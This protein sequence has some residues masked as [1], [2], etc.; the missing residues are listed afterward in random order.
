MS[1]SNKF[2]VSAKALKRFLI[3]CTEKEPLKES[4]TIRINEDKL[5]INGYNIALMVFSKTDFSFSLNVYQVGAL[6]KL[7][8]TLE[9]QPLTILNEG[10]NCVTIS[11][12]II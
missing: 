5:S 4:V 8:G 3:E 9:D 1:N 7:L 11:N 6:I 2:I 12:V 10:Y